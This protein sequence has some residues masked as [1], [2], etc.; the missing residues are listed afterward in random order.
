MKIGFIYYSF[1]PVTGGASVHGFNLA[2][3]M[4]QLGYELYK[5]NGEPDPYT[6]KL[7]NQF[8]GLIWMLKECDLFYIRMDYFL[9]LRNLVLLPA[10]LFNKKIIV[11]LNSPSDELHLFGKEKK[12][13]QRADKIMGYLLGKVD[14][15]VVVSDRLKQYCEE[16][17]G[18]NN[19][20][21][22]EN[23]GEVFDP[24][25]EQID[26]SVKEEI[27]SIKEKY[28]KLVV[29]SGSWNKMQDVEFVK[30]AINTL[31]EKTAF[32]LII[33]KDREEDTIELEGENLFIFNNM[34]RQDVSY[35]ISECD[36]GLAFYNDYPWSRWGF[37][38]SSLKIYEYMNNGLLTLTNVDG[39][40]TQ[41]SY[42]NFKTL[43]SI[44]QLEKCIQ[45]PFSKEKMSHP[46]R[47]WKTVA[48][49]TS[50]LINKVIKN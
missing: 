43:D 49:E 25:H 19:V 28:D 1:Y 30:K 5:I 44:T 27:S 20:T 7:K 35:I 11:E 39:T 42:P 4:N 41:K 23:G 36:I 26:Q 15:V 8:T 40:D 16:A 29:W 32:L 14:A 33:K 13:V 37:Y 46:K 3:E 17:L 18:L 22:I 2:K 45:L 24:D 48:E 31:R 47:T 6:Q 21:V 10:L 50:E 34:N 12:Q 9:N 38:N